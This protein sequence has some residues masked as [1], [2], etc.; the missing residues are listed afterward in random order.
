MAAAFVNLLASQHFVLFDYW[1]LLPHVAAEAVHLSVI[2][3][4][5]SGLALNIYVSGIN[6]SYRVLATV[7]VFHNF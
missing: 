5:P 6:K 4:S 2:C 7:I 3:D 1:F